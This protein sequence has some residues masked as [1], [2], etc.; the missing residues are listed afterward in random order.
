[1]SHDKRRQQVAYEA[2]RRMLGR[3]DADYYRAKMHA[4]RS[5]HRGWTRPQDLPTNR[6][7]RDQLHA[8]AHFSEGD[9]EAERLRERLLAALRLMRLLRHY[10][11]RLTGPVLSD[12][13]A[14][15]DAAIF[16]Y[17]ARA[18]EVAALLEQEGIRFDHQPRDGDR[19]TVA[20]L[21]V[22]GTWPCRLV[23]Y[24][25]G[26][27]HDA[28]HAVEG[29][30]QQA[31]IGQLE[32]RL[33]QQYPDMAWGAELLES[34]GQLDRFA[35]Y[36]MLLLPLEHVKQNPKR[37]PEGDALY[38]SLQVFELARQAL[39]YDEEFLLA[40]LLHDAGKAIDRDNH[41]AAAL[42]ALQGYITPRTAWLIEH[43]QEAAALKDGTLGA[44][45]RRR[46]SAAESYDELMLLVDCDRRGRQRGAEVPEVDEALA[47]VRELAD[48][49]GD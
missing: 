3:P 10:R 11:P 27:P 40:A 42:E 16:L 22:H 13:A 26:V 4:A 20:C 49:C 47:Y 33:A 32:H 24:A 34:E 36:E 2:A 46:L 14:D 35:V 37:H 1:M 15:G 25:A 12:E 41:V 48:A 43:H 19:A 8:M 38:H 39:P 18:D 28:L 31:S 44:R 7:I 17:E 30:L 45:S 9:A 5:I 6:E 29:P 23:L 21:L